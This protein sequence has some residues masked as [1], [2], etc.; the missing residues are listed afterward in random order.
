MTPTD[1]I[2]LTS[3]TRAKSN[4]G[5]PDYEVRQFSGGTE[6][7]GGKYEEACSMMLADGWK[8]YG[9]WWVWYD[10]DARGAGTPHHPANPQ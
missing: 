6:Y 10:D 7:D 3:I 2:L 5:V 4:G 9:D 1:A 8:R